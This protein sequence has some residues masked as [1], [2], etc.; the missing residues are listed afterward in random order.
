MKRDNQ[1]RPAEHR[2][3][4]YAPYQRCRLKAANPATPEY[5]RIM[6][7]RR[8]TEKKTGHEYR[9]RLEE[10]N[11]NLLHNI[12]ASRKADEQYK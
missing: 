12:E 11:R 8:D 1:W 10:F 5:S 7:E 9:Q 3:K 6:A 2:Y 4:E